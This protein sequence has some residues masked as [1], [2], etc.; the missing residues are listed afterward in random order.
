MILPAGQRSWARSAEV[1]AAVPERQGAAFY[2]VEL[3][4]PLPESAVPHN[5]RSPKEFA[6]FEKVQQRE[7][8]P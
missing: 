5:I 2:R 8:A 4:M 3:V 6:C 7:P 1:R